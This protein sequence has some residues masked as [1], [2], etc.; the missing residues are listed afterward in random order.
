MLIE[1]DDWVAENGPKVNEVFYRERDAFH[2]K[3]HQE[4][5]NKK[6]EEENSTHF[7]FT[8]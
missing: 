2:K 7:T 6:D 4:F 8:V 1:H 3:E 5:L